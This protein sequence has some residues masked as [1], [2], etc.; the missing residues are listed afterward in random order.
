LVEPYIFSEHV[1]DTRLEILVLFSITLKRL[2]E[3][4]VATEICDQTLDVLFQLEN[5]PIVLTGIISNDVERPS[6]FI[7]FV[8]Y[9]FNVCT[10]MASIIVVDAHSNNET[11]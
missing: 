6:M 9:E 7:Y 1:V 11:A 8:G 2:N 3:L 4:V 10:V 5:A